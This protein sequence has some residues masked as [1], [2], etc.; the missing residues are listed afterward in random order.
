MQI[1]VLQIRDEGYPEDVRVYRGHLDMT[2][3]K[4]YA[5]RNLGPDGYASVAYLAFFDK[6]T[7]DKDAVEVTYGREGALAP[8]E[9]TGRHGNY[10]ASG[11]RFDT[12]EM[13]TGD[14]SVLFEF[15]TLQDTLPV[16]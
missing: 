12:G 9:I 2:Q 15:R 3:I 13:G 4:K 11:Q 10:E 1:T 16:D 8:E 14:L 7:G 5:E 6:E